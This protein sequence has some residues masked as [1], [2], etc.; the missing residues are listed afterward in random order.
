MHSLHQPSLTVPAVSKTAIRC[1]STGG[2]RQVELADLLQREYQEEVD[3][4]STDLPDDL[5]ALQRKLEADWKILQ[6]GGMT[7]L[8]RNMGTTKVQV[9]FHCQDTVDVEDDPDMF[10]ETSPPVRFTVTATRGSQTMVITCL[11]ENAM[12]RIQSVAL[13]GNKQTT[14]QI[15]VDGLAPA[16]YQGP[17]FGELAEDLQEAFH[18]YIEEEMGLNQDVASFIAMY[19]DYQEQVQYVDFLQKT[20]DFLG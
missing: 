9:S 12:V 17:E 6:D 14:E 19:T 11:S 10:E 18:A 15:Q 8:L 13:A 1:F 16:V 3:S 2:P 5:A 20:R 4:S 7:R